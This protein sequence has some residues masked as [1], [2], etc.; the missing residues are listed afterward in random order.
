MRV[1]VLVKATEDSEK[2][3]MPTPALLEAMGNSTRSSSRPES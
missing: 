2:G 3:T 1:M